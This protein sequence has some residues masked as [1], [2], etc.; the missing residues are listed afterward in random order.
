[1]KIVT[2]NINSIN[3]RLPLLCEYINVHNPDI[4]LLQELKCENIKFPEEVLSEFN[5][6]HYVLGQKTYNGVAILSKFIADEVRFTF[7]D[8]PCSNQSRFIEISFANND[9]YMSVI[10][11]YAP[12]GSEVGSESFNMKIDFYDAFI[13]YIKALINND[14]MLIIGGDY[15]IAPF[16]IDVYSPEALKNNTCFTSI[17]KDKMRQLLNIGLYDVYRVFNPKSQEFS[18][19]DYRA[20]SFQQNKG[21]RIDNILVC[22]NGLEY[23]NNSTIHYDFR[24]KIKPSDHAPVMIY[25]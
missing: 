10:S 2:W 17:E 1:M 20:G 11:L 15:N 24:A 8:N 21:M 6:N 3:M 9:K 22:S 23:F 4:I 16:D 14:E 25:K 19:W 13:K 18:W 7:P 12:N 5:Y